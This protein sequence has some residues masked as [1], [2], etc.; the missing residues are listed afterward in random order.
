VLYSSLNFF[1]A[2]LIAVWEIVL[3]LASFETSTYP[4]P[5]T[6]ILDCIN[7]TSDSNKSF[8]KAT[9]SSTDSLSKSSTVV[10]P[11][12]SNAY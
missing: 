11:L 10:I 8:S 12:S 6:Y 4:P 5:D 3:V 7:L 2:S 1:Q 9:V